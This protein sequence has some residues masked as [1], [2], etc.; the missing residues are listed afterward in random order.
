MSGKVSSILLRLGGALLVCGGFF[1]ITLKFLDYREVGNSRLEQETSE[2]RLV[3]ATYGLNCGAKAGNMTASVVQVCGSTTG[4]CSFLIDA[5]K[6][7]DPAPGCAKDF[8]AKWTCG[9]GRKKRER[10]LR[11]EASGQILSMQCP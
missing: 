5:A 2:I 3:E 7:G 10:R 4:T 1:W 9:T 11:P 8:I 6:I